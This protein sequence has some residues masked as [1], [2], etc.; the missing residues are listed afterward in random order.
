MIEVLA[1]ARCILHV[2]SVPVI[3]GLC[4][5]CTHAMPGLM[6][7]LAYVAKLWS[8]QTSGQRIWHGSFVAIYRIVGSCRRAQFS[9]MFYLYYFMDLNFA[10]ACTHVLYNRA[11]FAGLI[12]VVRRSSVKTAKIGPL[13]NSHYTVLLKS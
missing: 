2:H 13:E 6:P 12:F 3:I 11:F 7:G 1:Q 10:D 9:R 5:L 8:L 4:R